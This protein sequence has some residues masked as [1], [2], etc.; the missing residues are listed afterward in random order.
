MRSFSQRNFSQSRKTKRSEDSVSTCDNH[1]EL[2]TLEIVFAAYLFFLDLNKFEQA[3]G[4]PEAI[5]GFV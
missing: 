4:R 5:S 1:D 3:R 2:M